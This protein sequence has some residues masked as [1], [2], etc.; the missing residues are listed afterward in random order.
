MGSVSHMVKPGSERA[1]TW[2]ENEGRV[3]LQKKTRVQ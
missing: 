1:I 3:V 2:I